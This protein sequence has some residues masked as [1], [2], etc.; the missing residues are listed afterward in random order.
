[1][2]FARYYQIEERQPDSQDSIDTIDPIS[3]SSFVESDSV[4]QE[5]SEDLN[6]TSNQINLVF[7]LLKKV[8]KEDN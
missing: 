7:I 1:M 3:L 6:Q 4:E 5:S 2:R 8:V